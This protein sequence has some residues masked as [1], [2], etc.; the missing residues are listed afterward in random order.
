MLRLLRSEPEH[1][2]HRPEIPGCRILDEI[3]RGGQG[4]VYRA[5][6]LADQR[7]VA[8]KVLHPRF[9]EHVVGRRRFEREAVLAAT[10]DHPGIVQILGHG[11]AADGRPYL[12]MELVAGRPLSAVA[13]DATLDAASRHTIFR[14]LCDAVGHAHRRGVMHRDLKPA[15]VLVDDV[16]S[17]H[18]ARLRPR[19]AGDPLGDRSPGERDR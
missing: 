16:W 17:R 10:L 11:L 1:W 14:R 2:G 5:E 3:A 15:N 12:V 8:I 4:A 18:G 9:A 7:T 6:R 13:A 19:A